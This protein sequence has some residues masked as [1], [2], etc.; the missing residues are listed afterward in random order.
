M[1]RVGILLL[2]LCNLS[3]WAIEPPSNSR[4]DTRELREHRRRAGYR[5]D[6]QQA[7][8]QIDMAINNVRARLTT[9]GDVWWNPRTSE[10]RYIVPKVDPASGLPEVS[11]I[12]AG[13]VWL[14]GYD[15]VG[16]LKVAA[17]TYRSQTRNDFWPGPLNEDGKTSKDQCERWDRFFRVFGSDI[18]E[19]VRL[20]RQ[21]LVTGEEYTFDQ[22]PRDVMSWPSHLNPWFEIFYGFALPNTT[23]KLAGFWD[24]NDD[25]IYNPLDGDFP[26][27]EIRG[28]EPR[29]ADE[30][31]KLLP[32]E[33]IYWV[34]NDAGN[35]H[36]NS[37]GFEIN[38]EVQVQAFAYATNDEINDMTFQRYKLINRAF[39]IIERTYFAM[40]ADPDLGCYQ[41][42]YVGC[43]T[44]RSL[45]YVYNEDEVDGIVGC[46][47]AGVPTYCT[48]VP[49]LGIDYFRGPN[50]LD[51]P[52]LDPET[53]DT[54]R[55][56]VTNI[57]LFE[58]IG[59]SSFIYYNNRGVGDNPPGTTDPVVAIEFYR[60]LSGFWRDNTPFTYGGSGYNVGSTEFI[61]YA[62]P[63]A[64][65]DKSSSAWSM[66]TEALSFGDRRTVQASGPFTLQPGAINELIIGVVWLPSQR[67][68][69]PSIV[70]LQNVD[71]IAQALFDSCFEIT[72]GPDAPD[73]YFVEMDK[74]LICVLSND[75]SSNNFN[76]GYIG[77]DI[78]APENAIDKDYR[79]EGYMVYQLRSAEVGPSELN[80]PDKARLIYQSDLRNGIREI[81]NWEPVTNPAGNFNIF[82]PRL[83]VSG[84]DRD[85]QRTF[86]ITEDQ[87]ATTDRRLV[88]HKKYYYMAIAYAH[89]DY[90]Y[91]STR[92]QRIP[93]PSAPGGFRDTTVIDTLKGFDPGTGLGQRR[94][95]LA[96]RRNVRQY[97]VTP[98]PIVYQYL[99]TQYGDGFEITRI[100]GRGNGGVFV[101]LTDESRS[102]VLDD[103][104]DG[105]LD[106][107]RGRGPLNVKVINPLEL[108]DADLE[109][110]LYNADGST[111]VTPNT[112]WR[113]RDLNSGRVIESD[114]SLG[115]ANEQILVDYGISLTM[116]LIDTLGARGNSLTAS[117][118]NGA[119]GANI[120][121]IDPNK[122][123]W[124]AGV[125]DNEQIIPFP[126]AP[127]TQPFNYIKNTG[128]EP[129][130]NLDPTRRLHR[131]G[132]GLFAPMFIMDF[133]FN[134][135]NFLLSPMVL[136]NTNGLA[137]RSRT[138]RANVPNVD[139]VLTPDRSK[140]SRCVVVETGNLHHSAA[141]S[142]LGV[143]AP[144]TRQFDR[145]TAPS[146]G[147]DGRYATSD[148]TINGTPLTS[149]SDNPNDPNYL[150]PTGMSWFPGYAI[151]VDCG[152]RLNIFFGENTFFTSF[153]NDAME[154]DSSS[155]DIC[156]DMIWNP[157]SRLYIPQYRE[158]APL[159]LFMGGQHYIYVTNDNYD[160]CQ[161][162]YP[163]LQPNRP[164]N[165]Q[166]LPAFERIAWG[167]FPLPIEGTQ[168]TSY[169]EGLIPN[170]TIIQL[171][172]NSV[173]SSVCSTPGN[174]MP[175]YIVKVRGEAQPLVEQSKIDSALDNIN[176]VPNPY[177]GYSAYEINQFTNTIKITNLPDKC[178][179]TIYSLDGKFIRQYNRNELPRQ[180]LSTDPGTRFNQTIPHLEWDLRN[181]RN[182]PIASGVYLIHVDAG[183]LGQRVI[184]WFGVNRQF[185]P[186]GL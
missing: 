31:L 181:F 64:P 161:A 167:G 33:M 83:M 14:G 112:R 135:T 46:A 16:N 63:S 93:D 122:P 66:C 142:T 165:L 98:R 146:L 104:F 67:Y 55:N 170:E 77:P 137:L 156:N 94:V 51:K 99:G 160:G 35:I 30:A 73:L 72:D 155:M 26:I 101:E 174:P 124:F 57:P 150:Q 168:L 76:E 40:W 89:N 3:L 36:T 179:V 59:M 176:V 151:D 50:D 75:E 54:L 29:T 169:A 37:N 28:C 84:A 6:C 180:N 78:L 184:K 131:I 136:D 47:C 87:F 107:N 80:D 114:F 20:Y 162:I 177:Y 186:S 19:H 68:P 82:V 113:I 17:Q 21:S 79:F 126:G 171:R 56:P 7:E 70:P 149:A 138:P 117:D 85:I 158:F 39:D 58:E 185:D 24:E 157:S 43:D 110:T 9:G 71:D 11:S 34:Y 111:A 96:G 148:G 65:D 42:D 45:M 147:I 86:V 88:N 38:M 119:I 132:E 103:N 121:F 102:R 53:G 62:F 15:P 130:A 163:R 97:I 152:R 144:L 125:P 52:I 92:V 140:W 133:R 69:C 154:G 41:D 5:S 60:Y 172:V 25:G 178:V 127:N 128:N 120:R 118:N 22:V 173:Y 159:Y 32:D 106:H 129:D 123:F 116:S 100:S 4:S 143:P 115:I 134:P 90:E 8:A 27:I 109:V 139:I 145:R 74:Q 164:N 10:G 49:I 12:F 182:I 95:F 108:Q 23:Q 61:K 183:E 81:Y 91:E 166:K 175:K 48:N 2:I 153:Y 18:R 44:I 105:R 141:A 1:N 13:A